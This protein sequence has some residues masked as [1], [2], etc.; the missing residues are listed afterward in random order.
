M[1][2]SEHNLS[3]EDLYGAYIDGIC[4]MLEPIHHIEAFGTNYPARQGTFAGHDHLDMELRAMSDVRLVFVAPFVGD[5]NLR[6][7]E[8]ATIVRFDGSRD[9]TTAKMAWAELLMYQECSKQIWK[10]VERGE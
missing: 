6:G 5:D 7:E 2:K 8:S 1:A 4:G 9:K 10:N 3:A